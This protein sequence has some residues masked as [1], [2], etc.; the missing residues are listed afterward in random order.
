LTSDLGL[1]SAELRER[2]DRSRQA[3]AGPG[4]ADRAGQAENQDTEEL[5]IEVEP[6]RC[7]ACGSLNEHGLH[8]DLHVAADRSWADL[9]LGPAFQGWD[10]IAHGGIVCTILDEVMAWALASTDN[11][12]VT[13]RLA[14]TFRK[15]VMIGSAIH[16]E[17]WITQSRR[18]IIET[19]ARVVDPATGTILAEATATY[20]AADEDRKRQLRARYRFRVRD[21]PADDRAVTP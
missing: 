19:A 3:G 11:W 1:R 10:G 18:R 6:H 15:P 17:G 20:V 4:R 9:T 5:A 12:G 8:L 13:A 7:F 2:V 14:V 16:A 21:E